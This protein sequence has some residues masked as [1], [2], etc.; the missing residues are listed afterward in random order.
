MASESPDN[1]D[2]NDDEAPERAPSVFRPRDTRRAVAQSFVYSRV[3]G[4]LRWALPLAVSL[5]LVALVAWPMIGAEKMKAVVAEAIPNL[6]VENLHL[7]GLD[8]KNQPYSLTA[9]KALQAANVKNLI[10]LEKPQGDIT[11]SSGAW[12]A[13][14]AQYGRFDQSN[15]QLWLGGD[16]Q[17]F[18]DQ[19]FQFTTNEAQ[20]DLSQNLAWGEQPV[21]IQG[22]FGEIRGQGFRVL[23]EGN[24]I[25]IKGHAEARLN[26]QA[27][28][29]SGT[30]LAAKPAT[31]KQG[32][33]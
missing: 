14:K 7:M 29:A 32:K 3:V 17:L 31:P 27:T 25:V 6:V 15:K 1:S 26:L 19:G 28:P 33:H 24:V 4:V 30:P 22:A 11:L 10:D 9:A 8:A 18:H 13:G 21:L 20:V 2:D 5:G 23:D 16:V 12:L